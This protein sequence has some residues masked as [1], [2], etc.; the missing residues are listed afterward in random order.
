[1]GHLDRARCAVGL[2]VVGLP[3]RVCVQW[4]ASGRRNGL[5]EDPPAPNDDAEIRAW[6][7]G[8]HVKARPAQAGAHV[9][10]E[11]ALVNLDWEAVKKLWVGKIVEITPQ[12]LTPFSRLRSAFRAHLKES[13]VRIRAFV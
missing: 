11:P 6:L 1:M 3:Y 8:F 12:A 9:H 13:A 7:G 10:F 2:P 5:N 4:V